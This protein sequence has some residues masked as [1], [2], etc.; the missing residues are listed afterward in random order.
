M[1]SFNKQL[2]IFKNQNSRIINLLEETNSYFKFTLPIITDKELKILLNGVG[3]KEII[4]SPISISK[5]DIETIY[6]KALII[7]E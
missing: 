5:E 1:D 2:I 4:N 3:K 7:K 6:R